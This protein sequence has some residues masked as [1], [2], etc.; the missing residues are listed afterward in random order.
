MSPVTPGTDPGSA[1]SPAHTQLLL[2]LLERREGREH[3]ARRLRLL[4]AAQVQPQVVP[5]QRGLRH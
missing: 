2:E 4:G 1:E 3:R 5:P